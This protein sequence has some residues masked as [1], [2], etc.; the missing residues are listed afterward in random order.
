MTISDTI[1]SDM[2]SVA[3]AQQ[4]SPKPVPRTADRHN[5]ALDRTRY[6]ICNSAIL[7][8]PLIA[9][10]AA[11]LNAAA[12]FR[13]ERANT[14]DSPDALVR[15]ASKTLPLPD[16]SPNDSVTSD[17]WRRVSQDIVSPLPFSSVAIGAM[18]RKK[19]SADKC[20]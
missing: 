4:P 13:L 20:M 17:K 18:K 1:D 16:T 8:F 7:Q 3:S 5:T 11:V 15:V 12:S 14:L 9:H 19:H 6:V 10:S 2:P